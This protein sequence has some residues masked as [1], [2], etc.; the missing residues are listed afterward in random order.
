MAEVLILKNDRGKFHAKIRKK[1]KNDY[2][3]DDYLKVV[4]PH[5]ANDLALLFEDLEIRINA[6]IEKAYLHY[7]ERK[8]GKFP[9]F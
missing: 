8:K 3:P 9:F 6:P 1:V 5:D 4:N 7:L 2:T